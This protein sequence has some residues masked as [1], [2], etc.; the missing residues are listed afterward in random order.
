MIIQ[1]DSVT[2]S[3]EEFGEYVF[4]K[5][6][7]LTLFKKDGI[8]PDIMDDEIN[9]ELHNNKAIIEDSVTLSR[10]KFTEYVFTKIT[11]LV[12]SKVD[13]ASPDVMDEEINK[14]LNN[15]YMLNSEGE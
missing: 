5:I 1:K 9:K 3:K 2:L 12:K 10:E 7:L 8:S 14:E 11:L 6:A 13:G 15:Y 4:A